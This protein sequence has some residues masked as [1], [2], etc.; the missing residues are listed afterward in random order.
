MTYA[1]L[2]ETVKAKIASRQAVTTIFIQMRYHTLQ[3]EA[4]RCVRQL[5]DEG[6]IGREWDM[7]LGG[8]PVLAKEE[9]TL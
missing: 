1:E 3:S 5:Q 6:L 7:S 4:R 8:Y 9:T 2:Y